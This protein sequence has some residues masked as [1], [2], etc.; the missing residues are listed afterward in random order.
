MQINIYT[1]NIFHNRSPW[2]RGRDHSRWS[3]DVAS[4]FCFVVLMHVSLF[5]HVIILKC[6]FRDLSLTYTLVG[7][8]LQI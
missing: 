6:N 5:V 3:P 2:S 8:W 7:T 1:I 4:S